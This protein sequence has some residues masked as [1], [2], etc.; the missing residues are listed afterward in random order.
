[1]AVPFP[2]LALV[3]AT[4]VLCFARTA[5][6]SPQIITQNGTVVISAHD[7]VLATDTGSISVGDLNASLHAANSRLTG[8]SSASASLR[9]DLQATS[10]V[11]WCWRVFACVCVFDR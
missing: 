1:M 3:L 4:A 7:V 10:V 8:L 5:H 11:R 6:S 9:L 2:R